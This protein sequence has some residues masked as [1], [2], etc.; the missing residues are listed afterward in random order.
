M[1]AAPSCA[2]VTAV[3]LTIGIGT[4]LIA[5]VLLGALGIAS[6]AMSDDRA[7]F[8]DFM[9]QQPV[10]EHS[11][12]GGDALA[13]AAS[14]DRVPAGD[15]RA[16]ADGRTVHPLLGHGL[17]HAGGL[18]ASSTRGATEAPL[19]DSSPWLTGQVRHSEADVRANAAGGDLDRAHALPPATRARR[20]LL[21]LV[22]TL[23][24][25]SLALVWCRAACL[26][27]VS[28]LTGV[29][30]TGPETSAFK[31][32]LCQHDNLSFFCIACCTGLAIGFCAIASFPR[33]RPSEERFGSVSGSL[34]RFVAVVV[35][36]AVVLAGLLQALQLEILLRRQTRAAIGRSAVLVG[37]LLAI[38]P[39]PPPAIVRSY[40]ERLVS[41]ELSAPGYTAEFAYLIATDEEGT[42]VAWAFDPD[43]HW[44]P[45]PGSRLA[46]LIA[47]NGPEA[48][49]RRDLLVARVTIQSQGRRVG[50]LHAGFKASVAVG[51]LIAVAAR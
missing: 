40:L 14:V 28:P 22:G 10:R 4:F 18:I 6:A 11:W 5:L 17:N 45:L 43:G 1:H 46:A 30:A 35:V 48:A 12:R 15:G 31:W 19:T 34:L 39:T 38:E 24:Q 20:V 27:A 25:A 32:S 3:F 36:A 13:V 26:A 49:G 8:A 50:L 9:A 44:P 7:T 47:A 41:E 42:P 16:L 29:R 21:A 33:P 2:G 51:P 37:D 23:R